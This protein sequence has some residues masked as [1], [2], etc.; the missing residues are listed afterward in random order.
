MEL[1]FN[2]LATII[3]SLPHPDAVSA[4]QEVILN[5]KDIPAWPQLP[6]RSFKENMYAQFSQGLPG[7]VIDEENKKIHVEVSAGIDK[8]IEFL[9]QKYI[10]DDLEYFGL[11]TDYA[12]GFYELLNQVKQKNIQPQ[13]IKGH[14]T[15]PITFGLSVTDQNKTAILYHPELSSALIKTLAMKA[16][17]QIKKIQEICP[18]VII[19]IDEPYLT[20]IGSAYISLNAQ[21]AV[22][23]LNEI[24]EVI[25]QNNAFAGIHCCGNTD[26]S[27]L[28]KTKTDIINFDAYDFSQTISLYPEDIGNFLDRGGVLAWGIVPTSPA[29][30]KE[31]ANSLLSRLEKQVSLL[32]QKGI[33]EKKIKKQLLVTPSCG[34][35]SLSLE[36]AQKALRTL[37]QISQNIRAR[38]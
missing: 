14:I 4:C 15:G 12:A 25:H 16:R 20:S 33:D 2:G 32:G 9:Y 27:L 23:N 29:L 24:I 7:I 19:F 11:G 6:R 5:L 1:P 38:W 37:N 10:D 30:I 18:K 36:L 17:W 34:A 21:E 13:F 22:D 31:D 28:T 26:W 35:G 8:K 3:G